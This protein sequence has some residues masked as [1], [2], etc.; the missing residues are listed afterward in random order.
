MWLL[1]EEK[2]QWNL[3]FFDAA[4]RTIGHTATS[5]KIVVLKSTVPCGTRKNTLSLV[6]ISSA[7]HINGPY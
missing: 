2:G 5:D 4:V 1:Q 7:L 6:G 3:D